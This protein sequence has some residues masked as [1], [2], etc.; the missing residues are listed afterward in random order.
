M[1]DLVLDAQYKSPLL[2]KTC[3]SLQ[4][5]VSMNISTQFIGSIIYLFAKRGVFS[6]CIPL[7]TILLKKEQKFETLWAILYTY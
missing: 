3:K 5:Q 6:M 1:K 2:G 7:Y 4:F